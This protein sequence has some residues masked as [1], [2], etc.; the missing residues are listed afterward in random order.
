MKPTSTN[1]T[2]PTQETDGDSR[3]LPGYP[4]ERPGQGA[5]EPA[6]APATES[7]EDDNL[8]AD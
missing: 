6:P 4:D 7:T 8:G 5:P 1:D 3:G 2:W